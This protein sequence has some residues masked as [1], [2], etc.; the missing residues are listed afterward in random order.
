M[1]GSITRKAD[2]CAESGLECRAKGNAYVF[3][4][5][6]VVDW[7]ISVSLIPRFFLSSRPFCP[8]FPDPQALATP[9]HPTLGKPNLTYYE[10]PL[11]N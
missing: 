6:V 7:S 9:S 3:C 10:D 1:G 2:W 11:Y 4:G 8:S 5:V